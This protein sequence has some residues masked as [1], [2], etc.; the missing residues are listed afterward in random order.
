MG[1]EILYNNHSERGTS[2]IYSLLLVIR[3]LGGARYSGIKNA[4]NTCIVI[5]KN[6]LCTE[7][8]AIWVCPLRGFTILNSY[9]AFRLYITQTENLTVK[10]VCCI[11]NDK[12][13]IL[14]L[15]F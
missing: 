2:W 9:T 11:I 1:C 3:V 8:S 15:N 6:V 4:H 14:L 10:H 13:Y 7:A 12:N 5:S